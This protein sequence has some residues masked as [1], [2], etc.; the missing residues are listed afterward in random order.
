MKV[1]LLCSL[2][3]AVAILSIL[4]VSGSARSA[5]GLERP[6]GLLL[7]GDSIATG[8][9]LS[10]DSLGYGQR[11]ARAFRLE[12]PA[13][14]NLAQNGDAS[15]D[16]L[17]KLSDPAVVA[18]VRSADLIV[19]SI[20]GNDLLGP[21]LSIAE[22]AAGGLQADGAASWEAVV[23]AGPASAVSKLSTAM[24]SA[25]AQSQFQTAVKGFQTNF[26]QIV[27]KIRVLNPKARLYVQ[28]VYNPFSGL[29]G[30]DSVSALGE[31]TLR[32]LNAVIVQK[33]SSEQYTAVDVYRAFSGKA[34]LYT[35]MARF[36]VHPNRVGH[37]AIFNAVYQAVTGR[38]Y[39]L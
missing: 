1:K 21:F 37:A 7:L 29:K 24:G 8:Y 20:G 12:G 16:L 38:T 10:A 9:G 6:S 34:L 23:L 18:S 3:V 4:A 32:A 33:A 2:A 15:G 28:T 14:V 27:R 5:G 35:N 13:Y 36:D 26:S 22:E 25:A 31:T 19:I 11:L 30:F 39:R 17:A